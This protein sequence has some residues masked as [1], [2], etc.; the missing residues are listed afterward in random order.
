[1]RS[2]PPWSDHD[3]RLDEI[4]ID[5]ERR[6]ELDIALAVQHAGDDAAAVDGGILGYLPRW[7]LQRLL[8]DLN[9][10]ARI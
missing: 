4:E 5:L 6:I 9:D 10:E 1:M 8:Q 2:A 3:A 7:R